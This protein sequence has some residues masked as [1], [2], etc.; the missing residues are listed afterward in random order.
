VGPRTAALAVLVALVAGWLWWPVLFGPRPDDAAIAA[1][2]RPRLP[3]FMQL[4]SANLVT[5]ERIA[6][7]ATPTF[8]VRFF[9]KAVLT[10]T[11][12]LRADARRGAAGLEPRLEGSLLPLSGQAVMRYVDGAWLATVTMNE[13]PLFTAVPAASLAPMASAPSPTRH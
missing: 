5:S 2:L 1:A 3:P 6:G 10:S 7:Q 9:A 13:P 4:S 11:V 8:K 12:Y